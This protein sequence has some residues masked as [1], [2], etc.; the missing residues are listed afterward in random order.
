MDEGLNGAYNRLGLY[1]AVRNLAYMSPLRP[2]KMINR[3]C[4]YVRRAKY[5]YTSPCYIL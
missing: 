3:A 5:L 2:E 4:L 1:L